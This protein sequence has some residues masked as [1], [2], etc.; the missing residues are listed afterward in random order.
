[1]INKDR[2]VI[3]KANG[4]ALGEI[5]ATFTSDL[6]VIRNVS[7]QIEPGDSLIR[8]VEDGPDEVYTVLEAVYFAGTGAHYQLKVE[9]KPAATV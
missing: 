7:P 9:K 1:M 5:R 4:A 6:V 2:V 3:M 8:K